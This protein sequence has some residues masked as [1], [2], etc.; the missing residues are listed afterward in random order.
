VP[1]SSRF[2][3]LAGFSSTKRSLSKAYVF[4]P[5]T[6]R[7]VAHLQCLSNIVC[8]EIL[9]QVF[10]IL[11]PVVYPWPERFNVSNEC[12]REPFNSI[13]VNGSNYSTVDTILNTLQLLP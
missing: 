5:I 7:K 2:V 10:D 3:L 1:T 13:L 9:F 4:G 6:V 8:Y 11:V 12:H